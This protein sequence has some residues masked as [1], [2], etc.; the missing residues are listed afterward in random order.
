MLTYNGH[1]ILVA[2]M[3]IAWSA[4]EAGRKHDPLAGLQR[5][6]S[7]GVVRGDG[8]GEVLIQLGSDLLLIEPLPVQLFLFRLGE[9]HAAVLLE[10]PPGPI[11]R[12]VQ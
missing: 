5:L 2:L 4:G 3:L 1:G 11:E 12:I 9:C 8:V 7:A 6:A 10:E